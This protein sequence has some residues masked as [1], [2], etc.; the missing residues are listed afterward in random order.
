MNK[1][2]EINKNKS[3]YEPNPELVASYATMEF[4]QELDV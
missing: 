3:Y 2:A 4:K 1:I